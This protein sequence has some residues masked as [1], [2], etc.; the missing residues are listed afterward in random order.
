MASSVSL[1][2]LQHLLLVGQTRLVVGRQRGTVL[3][4]PTAEPEDRGCDRPRHIREGRTEKARRLAVLHAARQREGQPR[5][6][7]GIGHARLGHRGPEP[8]APKNA[9]RDAAATAPEGNPTG[10]LSGMVMF[11]A[12][13]PAAPPSGIAAREQRDAVLHHP[14]PPFE[15]G[16]ARRRGGVLHLRLLI[17]RLGREA[18]FEPQFGLMH[19]LAPRLERPPHD[20][21]FVVERHQFEIG[22]GDLRHER[23]AHRAPILHRREVFGPA[24]AFGP[25][26]VAPT[27]PAPSSRR[28]WLPFRGRC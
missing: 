10:R 6:T 27:G 16:D 21:Q 11:S 8:A 3:G 20:R 19:V 26:Q 22:R 28:P 23:H 4:L 13:P 9:R 12:S 25:A 15:I 18:P 1:E 5:E 24:P 14:D 17:D 7:V 2:N